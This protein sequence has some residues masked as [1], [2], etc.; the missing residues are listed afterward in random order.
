MGC[1]NL[2]KLSAVFALAVLVVL[3]YGCSQSETAGHG[4]AEPQDVVTFHFDN[5]RTGLNPNETLLSPTNVKST[6]FGKIGFYATD[7]KVDAQPLYLSQL[8]IAGA[9]HNVLY[10][11]TEHD[12]VYA[13]DAD[14]GSKIWHAS[15]L[16]TGE[17]TSEPVDKCLLI[18]PE[19]GITSTP[20]IDRTR[21]AIYV[22][23]MSKHG[24]TYIQRLHALDITSGAEMFG[25]PT[26]VEGSFPGTGANSSNGKVVFD[27]RQYA[28]RAAL[29]LLNGLVYTTWTSH[30]DLQPYTGWII[31]YDASTLAPVQVLN[32]TPNGSEG[33]VWMSGAGPAADADGN[34]LLLSGNGTFETDLDAKGFP[35]KGDFGNCFLKIA[36]SG[37]L[38]VA[39][40][41]TMSNTLQESAADL[42][43][44]SG[45]TVVLP[46][47][48][49]GSGQAR[50]L[51][52]GGGKDR[53]L[54]VVDRD[55]M[56]K[57]NPNNDDAIYQKV[58]LASGLW[59]TPAYFAG[60]VYLASVN[61]HLQQFKIENAKFP[62]TPTSESTNT[63][64]Y[65]G[66]TP[67]V[68]ANG[69]DN[70]IIWAVENNHTAAVLHAYLATDLSE[71]Y[72]SNQ[73]PASRDQFGPGNKFIAPV[74]TSGKVFVGTATGVAVFGSL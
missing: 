47:L 71:L 59:S 67:S 43:L 68:S 65:P 24:S 74:V 60:S 45:G 9:V 58:K 2:Q 57:F 16:G 18:E 38:N 73:A 15:M 44:G 48:T 4:M 56:G 50:H 42:D 25:G 14:T 41:F 62:A 46:D 28:E 34:L 54:Y 66:A 64:T 72:N 69:S 55:N 11:V 5:A 12:S 7:G 6:G 22:V 63:F 20:V 33:A 31:G 35:N 8:S 13:F 19:I 61:N 53:N 51:A 52:V 49:D 21:G 27:P 37:G 30:C 26:V 29:L 10:V 32:L 70:G 40:Y 39:D 36:T 23:A 3:M 1:I 17:T